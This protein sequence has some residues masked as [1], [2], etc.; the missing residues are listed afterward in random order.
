MNNARSGGVCGTHGATRK[1]FKYEG[2]KLCYFGVCGRQRISGGNY[3]ELHKDTDDITDQDKMSRDNND[4]DE[5][6]CVLI[7]I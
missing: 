2:Y 1:R 4:Q 6:P 7:A 3:C 5:T